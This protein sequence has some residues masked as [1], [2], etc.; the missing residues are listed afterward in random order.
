MINIKK[1]SIP[2]ILLIEPQIFNDE[3]GFF[4][5][6]F[7]QNEFEKAIDR[8]VNFVQDNQSYSKF[9]VLRGL[10]KQSYPFEQA[11]LVR[12]LSGEI[13]DVAVDVREKSS[14]YGK[15]VGG[16]LSSQ[17]LK[18]LWIPEGFLHGFVVLSES[19]IVL[20]KTNNFYSK[21]N[22]ISIRWDDEFFNINWPIDRAS[23]LI[24]EKDANAPKI[25]DRI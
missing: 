13:Y 6:S 11:K 21:E 9:G 18:Q 22:E 12:V 19:A 5:E 17:N 8:K 1:L 24:S 4:L 3:R 14:T 7:N 20:Y 25:K 10:H 16:Y 2:E 23:I 15:W